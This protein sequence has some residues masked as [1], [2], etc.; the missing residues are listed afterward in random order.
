[1]NTKQTKIDINYAIITHADLLAQRHASY[2]SEFVTRANG[3]LYVILAEVLK[4]HE[5][6]TASAKQ[7]QL[8]KQMRRLLKDIYNIKTQTNT[9]TTALVVKYVTRA[10]RKT[11]HVYGKVLD[12]AIGD[13]ITSD[14]LVEYIKGKGGIDKV[15]KAVAS[16]ETAQQHK[17]EETALQ[18]ALHTHL[19]QC[20]KPIATVQL[21]DWQARFPCAK[22]VAFHQLLCYFNNK[23]NQYEVVAVMYPSSALEMLSMREYLEMLE[24]ATYSDSNEFYDKCAQHGLNMDILL[25]WKRANDI[26]DAESARAIAKSLITGTSHTRTPTTLKLAA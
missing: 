9:K 14:G 20:H 22:D 6:L 3:E 5:M 8:V 7:E 24:V 13:G 4:L 26:A 25:R 1:M 17:A 16:A 15:R 18:K 11:A 2:V 19:N 23:T 10:S 21:A 12:I